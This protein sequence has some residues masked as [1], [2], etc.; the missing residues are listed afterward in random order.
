MLMTSLIL[1][2][3]VVEELNERDR[4]VEIERKQRMDAHLAALGAKTMTHYDEASDSLIVQRTQD[5]SGALDFAQ[6]SRAAH[7]RN[8]YSEDRNLRHIG[9]VPV[10]VI[11]DWINNGLIAGPNDNAGI[12]RMLTER[13]YSGFR[14]VDKL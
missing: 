11:E 1:P 14:T 5:A 9:E 3:H 6:A 12:R 7:P 4:L 10:V 2:L 8:G 13:D